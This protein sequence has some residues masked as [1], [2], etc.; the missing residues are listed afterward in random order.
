MRTLFL[1]LLYPFCKDCIH[2][3]WFTC[4]KT[5]ISTYQTRKNP[6]LC[7]EDATFFS[8]KFSSIKFNYTK[9]CREM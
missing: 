7:G 3:S 4:K 1:L 8:P 5:K 2:Q 9:K 6:S